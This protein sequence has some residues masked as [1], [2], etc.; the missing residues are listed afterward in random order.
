L[1]A[2]LAAAMATTVTTA[3]VAF[4]AAPFFAAA[5]DLK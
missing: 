5:T 4:A 1:I 3:M 2:T